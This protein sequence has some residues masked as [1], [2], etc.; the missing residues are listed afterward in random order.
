[1][2]PVGATNR[3]Q[4]PPLVLVGATNRDQRPCAARGQ[5]FSPTSLVERGSEW[6]ISSTAASLS[7]SSQMQAYGP[8]V[9]LCCLLAYWAFCGPESWPMVG[10][11]VVFRPW[12]PSRWHFFLFVTL[13][14]LFCFYLQQNTY[15]CYFYL[16]YFIK[17]YFILFYFILFCLYL[18]IL[19]KFI[20]FYFVSTYLFY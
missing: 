9:T 15:C 1:M 12:W 3:D 16:F 17:V 13:F 4:C 20:L 8:N 10:F 14:I 5:K 19:L 11:L 6:F 7:S 2:V 18:F